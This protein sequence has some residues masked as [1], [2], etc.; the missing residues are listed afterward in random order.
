[1]NH[2]ENHRISQ[3]MRAVDSMFANYER[4]ANSRAMTREEIIRA[5]GRFPENQK[6]SK[7]TPTPAPR[8]HGSTSADIYAEL[9]KLPKG[10]AATVKQTARDMVQSYQHLAE[11]LRILARRRA[12]EITRGGPSGTIFRIMRPRQVA[13]AAKASR[14]RILN[15]GGE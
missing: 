3:T 5:G 4:S 2:N 1:M 15:R 10:H 8:T 14:M 9:A 13:E 12:V 11:C 7:P 6:E